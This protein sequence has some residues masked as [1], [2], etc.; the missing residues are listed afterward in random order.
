MSGEMQRAAALVAIVAARAFFV[1]GTLASSTAQA[2]GLILQLPA[3]DQQMITAQLGRGVVDKALPS[4]RIDDVAIY[5][6][7]QEAASS[8]QVIAGPNAG[9]TQ[10]LGVAKV[11]RLMR[12]QPG[13]SSSRPRSPVSS[14]RRRTGT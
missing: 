5:F 10:T 7:L 8:Y 9:K 12:S 6:P 4:E 3:D 1:F 11:R 2:Q 13:A 14:G